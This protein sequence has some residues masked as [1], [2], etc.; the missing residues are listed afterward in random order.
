MHDG[1]WRNA[2]DRNETLPGHFKG[3]EGVDTFTRKMILEYATEGT[4]ELTHEPNGVFTVSKDQTKAAAVEVLETHL[5]MDAGAADAHL[6][7]Y[8]D[9]VW[10][11]FDV[12]GKGALDAIEL[13]HLMR[14]LCKPVKEHIELE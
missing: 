9:K 12:L 1:A 14:D 3:E 8:F 2:Y 7:Q 11:H 10:D 5:G 4:D 13:N 6:G